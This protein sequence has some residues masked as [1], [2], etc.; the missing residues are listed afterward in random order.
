MHRKDGAGKGGDGKIGRETQYDGR[1]AVARP[2]GGAQAW[3]PL[4]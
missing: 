1:A 4:R 3:V 2:G